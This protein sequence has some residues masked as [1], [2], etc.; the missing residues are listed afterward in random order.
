M[1]LAV[2]H[3]PFFL[4]F[5][6]FIVGRGALTPPCKPKR[7][8]DDR[9]RTVKDRPFILHFQFSI[10]NYFTL[11]TAAI[12][13]ASLMPCSDDTE[14]AKP[15]F[16]QTATFTLSLPRSST[17]TPFTSTVFWLE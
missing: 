12:T 3:S 5:A 1:S 16:D 7:K 13:S 4:S 2:H 17:E 11:L 9:K 10:L 14:Y 6:S 8:R 15:P